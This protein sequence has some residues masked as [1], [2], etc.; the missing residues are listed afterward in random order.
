MITVRRHPPCRWS[1]QTSGRNEAVSG[2]V[3][4]KQAPQPCRHAVVLYS[5]VRVATELLADPE[6]LRLNILKRRTSANRRDRVTK[7]Y[8]ERISRILA[9][10]KRLQKRPVKTRDLAAEFRVSASTVQRDIRI[11]ERKGEPIDY[12][13]QEKAFF[14]LSK[15]S[16]CK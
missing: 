10:L 16:L 15:G 8:E 3:F 4:W 14:L 13:E 11:L 6:K 7:Q 1:P 2:E 12:D 9:T 5:C